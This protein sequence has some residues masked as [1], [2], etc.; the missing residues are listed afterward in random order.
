[1]R[2]RKKC[3]CC[4]KLT[5]M[6]EFEEDL[7]TPDRRSGICKQCTEASEECSESETI[8][9]EVVVEN[10][11]VD[12]QVETKQKTKEGRR[13]LQVDLTTNKIINTYDTPALA[14][15]AIGQSPVTIRSVLRGSGKSAFGFGWKF[16]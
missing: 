16:E 4:N 6:R 8:S 5:L 14:G 2:I 9:E 1:M 3:E 7:T 12:L 15:A 13:V 10:V 11:S